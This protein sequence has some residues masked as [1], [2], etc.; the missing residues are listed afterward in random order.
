[1]HRTLH[2]GCVLTYFSVL[3]SPTGQKMILVALTID[4]KE[5]HYSQSPLQYFNQH[6]ASFGFG[7][8]QSIET[9]VPAPTTAVYGVGGTDFVHLSIYKA[10]IIVV[11][12]N[13]CLV[14]N[15]CLI[16]HFVN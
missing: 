14:P 9:L 8:A 16:T 11:N 15:V 10:V 2:Q 7:V 4:K 3:L 6:Q 12:N 5:N 13:L 1:M